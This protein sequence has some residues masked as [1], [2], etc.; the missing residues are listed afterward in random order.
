VNV[1]SRLQGLAEP[2]QVVIGETTLHA[3]NAGAGAHA[4]ASLRV[5]PLGEVTVKGRH[6]P[7]R[8][9]MVTGVVP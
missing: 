6:Q 4:G 8:A 5:E 9:F 7:V 1:A 2:G 3:V